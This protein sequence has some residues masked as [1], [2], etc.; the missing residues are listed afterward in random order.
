ME[1]TDNT[2]T[3]RYPVI[4][5]LFGKLASYLMH[6][7]FIPAHIFLLQM[8]EKPYKFSVIT[9]WQLKMR[10]FGLC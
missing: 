6:P 8:S 10:L 9:I 1:A 4:I 5:R 7:P 2:V 3:E